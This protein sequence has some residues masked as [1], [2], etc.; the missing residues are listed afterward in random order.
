MQTPLPANLSARTLDTAGILPR[1][2]TGDDQAMAACLQAYGP[3]VGSLAR[4][5]CPAEADDAIQ[6]IFIELW[7]VAARFDAA[8]ASEQ[9]FVAMI[10]RRRLI[11]RS[12]RSQARIQTD[13]IAEGQDFESEER[14]VAEHAELA[15]EAAQAVEV[16]AE[17]RDEQRQ[18]IELSIYQGLSHSQIT[19]RTGMPLGTVKTHL[20]RGL[21]AVRERLAERDADP[22][23]LRTIQ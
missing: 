2:A 5:L 15:D 13:T 6:E 17:L 10:A 7:R 8:K 16:L 4:R 3:L 12:R 19:E 20:R 22:D 1:V 9:A 21:I 23:A 18:V 14:G 11:D